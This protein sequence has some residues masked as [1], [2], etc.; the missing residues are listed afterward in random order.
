MYVECAVVYMGAVGEV[1]GVCV[2]A[3]ASVYVFLCTCT[4]I[5]VYVCVY[6][7]WCVGCGMGWN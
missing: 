3:H 6:R 4:Y 2:C 7:K 5:W 1:R